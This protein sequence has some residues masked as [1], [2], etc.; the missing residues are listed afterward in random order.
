MST[1]ENRKRRG[2]AEGNPWAAAVLAGLTGLAARAAALLPLYFLPVDFAKGFP[3]CAGLILSALVWVFAVIPLRCRNRE[4][5][6]RAFYSRHHA[7]RGVPYL[8]WLGAGLIR[9]LKG[10]LWGL[11]F[12][13]GLGYCGY[14]LVTGYDTLSVTDMWRPVQN[15]PAL[16]G[17]KPS[18][19]GG[20]LVAAAALMLLGVLFAYGWRRDMAAE[21]L[22]VR[23]MERKSVFRWSRRMRRHHGKELAKCTLINFLLWLPGALGIGAAAFSLR[24]RVDASG[25]MALSDSL[26]S[27]IRNG[28]SRDLLLQLSAVF[29]LVY[30]PLC[31]YRKMRIAKAVAALMREHIRKAEAQKHAA[32]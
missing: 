6:R 16:L 8:K 26:K 32:G 28:I 21:F 27:L 13:A 2:S 31:V 9:H 25:A 20:I 7:A 30:F 23:S 29:F 17:M 22:P 3:G 1:S 19:A 11:P 5:V 18:L 10:W 15:L 12:L 14:Y 24:G 4:S